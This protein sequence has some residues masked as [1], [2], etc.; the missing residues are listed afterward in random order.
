MAHPWCGT[1]FQVARDATVNQFDGNCGARSGARQAATRPTILV[2]EMLR[3]LLARRSTA[4]GASTK[5]TSVAPELSDFDRETLARVRP[6]TMTSPQRV[7]ALILATRYIVKRRIP[8]AIVECGVWRGGSM[9]ATARTLLD[10]GDTTR[11]LYLFDTFSGMPEPGPDDVRAHDGTAASAIL[12]DPGEEQT[13]AEASLDTVRATMAL[14]KFDPLLVHYVAGR[15]E[16]TVPAA[17]PKA[18]AL[19]RL[20]TDWY[21]STRHELEHLFP[22]LSAGGVLIIDDYGWWAGARR[23]VDE[24]FVGHSE[25]ILLNI[26]DDTGRIGVRA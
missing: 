5:G 18:I 23:A 12:K 22:R 6:H 10:A 19:L 8:G 26:I 24:Y 14:C 3:R 21:E 4:K 20:D 7:Q 11:E 17:A 25:P 16:E 13:R 2:T 1:S 15:V 9:L